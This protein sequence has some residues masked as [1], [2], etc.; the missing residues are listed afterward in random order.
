MNMKKVLCTTAVMLTL[1]G[2]SKSETR[3]VD[4]KLHSLVLGK[5]TQAEV[6]KSMGNPTTSTMNVGGS[7]TL[8]YSEEKRQKKQ[9][10]GESVQSKVVVLEIGADGVLTGISKTESSIETS[11]DGK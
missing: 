4:D 6:L 8:V 1:A 10:G 3:V 7:Q 9:A 5:S 11:S 2:C